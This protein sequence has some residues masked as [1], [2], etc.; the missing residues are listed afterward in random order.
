MSLLHHA[1]T[2]SQA[3][4]PAHRFHPL[5]VIGHPQSYYDKHVRL[6]EQ[7]GDVHARAGH[8]AGGHITAALDAKLSWDE[9]LRLFCHALSHH[10]V[11]PPDADE[12]IRAYYQKLADL[13][14]RYV[15]QEALKLIRHEHEKYLHRLKRGDSPE[16]VADEAD[17]FFPRFIG[18]SHDCPHWFTAETWT[19]IQTFESRWI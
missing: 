16:A 6:A 11:A 18:H 9:K 10:C 19:Q 12:V 3:A 2:P 4:L 17:L 5:P 14:R 15:G 8:K 1:A 13:V 7:A